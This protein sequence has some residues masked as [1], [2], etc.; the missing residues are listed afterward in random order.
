MG[1]HLEWNVGDISGTSLRGYLDLP[2]GDFEQT[3]E[4]LKALGAEADEWSD[5]KTT[6]Q[7]RGRY[8]GATFTLY[9]YY[10]DARLHIG[11]H[12]GNDPFGGGPALDVEGLKAHLGRTMLGH[13]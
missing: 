6:I 10:R 4:R 9:D 13:A 7:F 3:I 11:G 2:D 8:N 12:T 1:S 5:D